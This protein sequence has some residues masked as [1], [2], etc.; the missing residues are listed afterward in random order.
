MKEYD[1]DTLSIADKYRQAAVKWYKQ[2]HLAAM[3]DIPFTT[4]QPPKDWNERIELTKR[5]ASSTA[6]VLGANLSIFAGQAKEKGS[7]AKVV[8]GEKAQ[9]AKEKLIQ[10]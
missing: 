3:D 2:R 1:I 6:S 9:I 7:T 5:Q 10:A 4:V 8:I